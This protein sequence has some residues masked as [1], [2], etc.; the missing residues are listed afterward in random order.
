MKSS[1]VKRIITVIF[2]CFIF[3][4]GTVAFVGCSDKE[5]ITNVEKVA[6]VNTYMGQNVAV[7]SNTFENVAKVEI[8]N[9]MVTIYL[10]NGQV[11]TT[12]ITNVI[13]YYNDKK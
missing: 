12:H 1:K 7:P 10:S 2:L 11:V 9:D 6:I 4:F 13:I 8:K 5:V 3:V